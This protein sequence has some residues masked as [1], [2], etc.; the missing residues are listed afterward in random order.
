ML[1]FK[2]AK[3]NIVFLKSAHNDARQEIRASILA[4]NIDEACRQINDTEPALLDDEPLLHYR[5]LVRNSRH[6]TQ[7]KIEN[8]LTATK[9]HRFDT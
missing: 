4:G 2:H 5:L 1:T 7:K 9:T 6:E 8:V 3:N